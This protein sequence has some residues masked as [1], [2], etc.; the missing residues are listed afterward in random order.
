MKIVHITTIDE[1]G[2]YKAVERMNKSLQLQGVDS[3]ILLRNK[4]QPDNSGIV[5]L[6]NPLKILVSKGKNFFN[7]L[8]IF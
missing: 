6:D 5:F 2:A 1:G 7:L 4:I 8:A 3:Q